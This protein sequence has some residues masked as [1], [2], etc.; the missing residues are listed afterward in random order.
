MSERSVKRTCGAVLLV[1][2][3]VALATFLWFVAEG[4]RTPTGEPRYVALGSSFAAGADLGE[5]QRGSPTLCARSVNGYPQQ[6]ARLRH[7]AIVDM[8]C[9]G[10]V[11]GNVLRG[12]QFFQGAQLRTITHATRL[13]TLT[14]GGNDIGYIGDL[15]LLAARH[16][17][18]LFG[19]AVRTFWSG[20]KTLEERPFAKLKAELIL[21]IEAIRRR[22]PE[23]TLVVAT[24]PTILPP[25]GTCPLLGLT[26][27]EAGAMRAAGNQLAAVTRSAANDSGTLLVDMHVMGAQHHACSRTPWTRGW[28]NSGLAPF[29]PTLG[30][31]QATAFAVS[32]AL[33]KHHL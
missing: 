27:A 5:L 17:R 30:G 10:A 8:S 28:R 12:G 13:V 14:V 2:I 9:G 3:A 4:R 32:A 18:T 24:Y 21:T 20:P 29:H 15:S 31:A 26:A 6:L 11:T 33:A 7:L 22:A 16:D 1:L 23:A 19:W 25:A